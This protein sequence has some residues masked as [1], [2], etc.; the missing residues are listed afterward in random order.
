MLGALTLTVPGLPSAEN[1]DA[2]GVVAGSTL[3]PGWEFSEIGTSANTSYGVGNGSSS[4]GN[5]YSF[6]AT[7]DPDR[8][9]GS[10]RTSSLAATFGT[11]VT[12]LTGATITELAIEYLGEQW[13]LG[14]V[15]RSDRLD[16]AYSLDAT[17]IVT[18]NWLEFDALD[19]VAPVT[20]GATGA[21]DGNLAGN[22]VLVS[23]PLSGLALAPGASLWL[24]WSDFDASGSD[25]GLAIDDFSIRGFAGEIEAV[26]DSLPDGLIVALVAA[27]VLG[28]RRRGL[29][30]RRKATA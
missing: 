25:D 30:F 19:F 9:L 14:A 27:L 8:A 26:P 11:V 5:T 18:G 2:L 13:R 16:F 22:R 29:G 24:R 15:G 4:T 12:N 21:L 3:P 6:G 20:A 1:F 23:H 17:S 10:L 7:G 28:T